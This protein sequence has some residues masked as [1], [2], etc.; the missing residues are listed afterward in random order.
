V[1]IQSRSN[2]ENY[3]IIGSGRVSTDIAYRN[4]MEKW[5]WGNF[6]KERL[7]IDRSYMPSLQTMRVAFI[8]IGRQLIS[9][10]K[11]EQA[12]ALTDKYFEVF[13]AFNF[14]YDQFAALMADVYAK[15]GAKDKAAAKFREIAGFMEEILK[16]HASLEPDFQNAYQSDYQSSMGTVQLILRTAMDM[17][18]TA[19]TQE[20][21]QKFNPYM[22]EQPALPGIRQ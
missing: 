7:Y 5:S 6:D 9:E 10:G 21:Q 3:G 17:Q 1:P 2:T 15:A 4:I 11:T 8:R 19:L 12:I 13:P 16:F 22:S 18:D 20:L 14:P